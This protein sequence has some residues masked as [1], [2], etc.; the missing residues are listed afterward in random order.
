MDL[1][2][3]AQRIRRADFL[4]GL[5]IY[6]EP[7]QVSIAHVT[8]RLLRVALRHERSYPL[9]PTSRRPERAQT[10]TQAL[11]AFIHEFKIAPGVVHLCLARQEL[12][13]NRLV[14]P[15]AARENLRQVLEYEIERVIPLP[16][17]EV[18]WDYQ[19]RESGGGEAGRLA[20]LIVS[21][22]RRVV[23]EYVDALEAA[24]ARP[25]AVV[26]AASALGDYAAF[27]RGKLDAPL[28]MVVQSG[29]DLEVALFAERQLVASHALRGGV[30]PSPGELQQM[31][32]RDLA[33]VFHPSQVAVEMLYATAQNGGDERTDG[34]GELLAL[35]HGRL[36]APPEFFSHPEPGL[37]PAVG[38]ALGAVRESVVDVNLLP[39]EHR[40]GLQEGLFV[41]IVLLV[42][43]VVLA[44]V[45][46]GAV[47]V[48]D[49][50][51]RRSLARE[52]ETLEPQVA[53]VKKQE[54]EART[55]QARLETLT[56]DQSRR[57]ILFLK[58]LTDRL[59]SDA[60]L[61]TFRFRNGRIEIDGFANKASELIQALESSSM[62]RNVQFT[63]PTTAGQA[64]EERFSIVMEIEE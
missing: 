52:V 20:V 58:E 38:A 39:E 23:T 3:F 9:A 60:Y 7:E 42:A 17:D 27:C 41:P 54:A 21:V 35:A 55:L 64:G 26:I 11:G 29:A 46:G 53:A 32:R 40:P 31:V 57:M 59:P 10:L 45:Y 30:V 50:M 14:L 47:I 63:S 51:T 34:S 1:T 28:A 56:A 62:F 22:P 44:L 8:K 49:E 25:K 2:T 16:R 12:L 18:F 33:E 43:A 36:D 48:R 61:S 5:G 13:L 37:L 19:V 15:A 4:D 24:G 6:V